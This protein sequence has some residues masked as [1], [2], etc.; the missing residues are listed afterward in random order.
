M[1]GSRFEVGDSII[2]KYENSTPTRPR[3]SVTIVYELRRYIYIH[4]HTHTH[5]HNQAK[6]MI[7]SEMGQIWKQ[8]KARTK[9]PTSVTTVIF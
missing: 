1:F 9:Q 7:Y 6:C 2:R 5:T 4:T 3:L 8:T